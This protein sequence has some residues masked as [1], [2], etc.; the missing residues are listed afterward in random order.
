MFPIVFL[1]EFKTFSNVESKGRYFGGGFMWR[2]AHFSDLSQFE[3]DLDV[4][5]EIFQKF[6]H[7]A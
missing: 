1:H 4:H 3:Y 2:K 5:V 6:L 7:G